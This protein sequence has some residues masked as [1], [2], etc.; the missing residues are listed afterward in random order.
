MTASP[1]GLLAQPLS[2]S[3]RE[4]MQD[5][6]HDQHLFTSISSS[7]TVI[8]ALCIMMQVLDDMMHL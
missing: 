6:R 1:T 5:D 3:R 7:Q 2:A 8:G 4:R